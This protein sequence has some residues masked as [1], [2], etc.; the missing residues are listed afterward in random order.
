GGRNEGRGESAVNGRRRDEGH[1]LPPALRRLRVHTGQNCP[2]SPDRS[3]HD[4]RF[5]V[6]V[7]GDDF[8]CWNS[9]DSMV[10]P[11]SG[12]ASVLYSKRRDLKQKAGRE[13]A[14]EVTRTCASVR[15]HGFASSS[16]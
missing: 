4:G 15:F 8:S 3:L 13:R 9:Q 1:S 6:G 2:S 7:L 14:A 12:I 10:I 16:P 5:S 11:A